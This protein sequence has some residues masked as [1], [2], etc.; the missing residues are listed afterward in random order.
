MLLFDAHLDL[1]LNAVEWNRDLTR[2]LTELRASEAKLHDKP[3]RRNGTVCL[4]EMRKAQ[5][6]VCVATRR[7]MT[8]LRAAP[9]RSCS[10]RISGNRRSCCRLSAG[11]AARAARRVRRVM[12]RRYYI[13]PCY[14][15]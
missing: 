1:A 15:M 3:D 10:P 4:P 5:I 12:G 11:T 14:P 2:P 9:W 13:V 6:G 7:P 8:L